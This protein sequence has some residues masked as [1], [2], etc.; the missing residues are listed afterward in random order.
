MQVAI[1]GLGKMGKN[2]ALNLLGRGVSVVGFNRSRNDTDELVEKGAVGVYTLAEIPEKFV[3]SPIVVMLFIPAGAPVDEILFGAKAHIGPLDHDGGREQVQNG[4][5]QILPP[6]SIVIDGGN[7]F[8]KDS[9]KRYEELKKHQINFLDMGTSGGLEGARNGACLMVGGNRE[10]YNQVAALL[11]KIATEK[12]LGYIGPSGAGHFVKMVHNAIEYGM[13]GAIAEGFNLVEASE[14]KID[15]AQLA[16]VWAHGSI[17]SGLLMSKA[18]DAL[19]RDP[20]LS[21]L[22]GQVPKGETESE[23]EWLGTIGVPQPVIQASLVQRKETRNKPSFIGKLLAALR[24]EFGGHS[25][26]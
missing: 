9:Q 18:V 21:Q 23:M 5:V 14:F 10:V 24:R 22:D 16:R 19:Y 6:G 12:G 1:V 15:L 20:T 2:I 7:S 11:Q 26:K 3:E 25:V 4:L 8:Y 13:M 17:V